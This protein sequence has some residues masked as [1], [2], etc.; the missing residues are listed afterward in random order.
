MTLILVGIFLLILAVILFAVGV[1]SRV[2]EGKRKADLAKMLEDRKPEL[3]GEQPTVLIQAAGSENDALARLLSSFDFSKRWAV[4][5]QQAGMTWT[6]AQMVLS[7]AILAI[8]G[9]LLGLRFHLLLD[10]VLSALGLAA[11]FATFPLLIVRH[12]RT[13]RMALF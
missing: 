4:M 6:P 3:S 10:P 1:G 13:K 11:V 2:D 5:I 12:K 7:M 9:G 8:I